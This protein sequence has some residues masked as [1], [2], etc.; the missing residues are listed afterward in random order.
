MNHELFMR[1]ALE[2]ASLG[3]GKVSPNPMVGCVIVHGGKIIGEGWHRQF[4]GPH[5]E[6]NAI[7]S[8]QDKTLLPQAT[9]YVTLEPCNHFGKTPPCSDLILSHGIPKVVVANV[10]PN[11][12]VAGTGLQKLRGK[13]VE[14]ISGVL[15]KEGAELNKRFFT[16]HQKKRP[17]VLLKWA[18]TADGFIARNNFDSKWISNGFSRQLVHKWRAEEDLVMVG[19]Q[20]AWHDNPQLNV[21]DWTDRNPARAVIDYKISLPS[22]HHLFD[23]NQKTLVFNEIKNETSGGTEYIKVQK[24]ELVENLLQALYERKILSVMVEGGTAL[25]NRFIEKGYWDEARVFTATKTFGEGIA[26]PKLPSAN[27]SFTEEFDV[28][29]DNLS[30]SYNK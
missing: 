8:V 17:F 20:T 4:G 16:F 27:I 29:G 30:V 10:D 24:N 21:R 5:A 18:Q 6:P 22:T 23:N 11:P 15:E 25:L 13:G 26:A 14:V 7:A 9:L 3:A 19:Y 2:L 1:R 12:L 28:M